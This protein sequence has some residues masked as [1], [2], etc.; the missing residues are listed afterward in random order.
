[1]INAGKYNHK[2]EIYETAVLE[3][4]SGF[5]IETPDPYYP[6]LV[7]SCYASVKTTK[8]ITLIK[9]DSDFEKAY[10]NF[11]IR[12]P[13]VE[14]NRDMIVKFKGK[15]YTIEYINNINEESV[16]LELQ[17]KEITH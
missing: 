8:G 7:L 17:C 1:M 6:A 4:A 11:T 15:T 2:I 10:T 13:K 3:D 12:F 14:I 16:E 5:Q 9:N